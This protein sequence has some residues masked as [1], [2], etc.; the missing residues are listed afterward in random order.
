MEINSKESIGIEA[1]IY[2]TVILVFVV[3]MTFRDG[4]DITGAHI[5]MN[6]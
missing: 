4:L 3:R 1:L 2:R 5:N 6:G